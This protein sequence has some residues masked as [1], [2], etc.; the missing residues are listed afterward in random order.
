MG[1]CNYCK[2]SSVIVPSVIGYCATCIREHFSAVWPAIKQVHDRSR[3]AFGL[4][5]DP[6]RVAGGKVCPQ[7]FRKCQIPEGGRGYCGVRKVENGI[8]KG[9]LPEDG[10]LSYYYDP[11]PTNCVADFVCPAGT[12]CGFPQYAKFRGPE[13][14][15]R[16]LAVFYRACSFNCLYC[17]NA[18]FKDATFSSSTVTAEKLASA[19]DDR[20]TCICY[21][22]GD[23]S[24]Q[25]VHALKASSLARRANEGRVLRICW[26]T[27]GALEQPFLK[28][29]AELSLV[30]G[31]CIKIDLKAWSD[32][33]HHALCGVSN[34]P[35]LEKFQWLSRF[36]PERPEPPFLIAST[37]LVPGYVDEQEVAGIAAF[38][39][40]LNPDIPYRLLAFY[41]EFYLR[42]LPTTSKRYA[43]R[44][45]EAAWNAGLGRVSV[46]NVHL[47]RDD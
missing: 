28:R 8:M 25:I 34:K 12:G 40:R 36:V 26:E 46:G 27:N 20:T 24:P 13:R 42:D 10:N 39:A 1:T 23:P 38:I 45:Q 14:G 47:L 15:Y 19:V 41:P 3:L 2:K 6:P 16:N 7:C 4:P 37:L 9:G 29:A 17:Q 35:T 31:G 22:G 44:C 18:Q 5:I 32:E 43:L 33:I 30:S 21:F 11:L